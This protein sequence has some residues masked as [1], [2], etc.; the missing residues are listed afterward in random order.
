VQDAVTAGN[1]KRLKWLE[2]N[3]E[4]SVEELNRQWKRAHVGR[5]GWGAEGIIL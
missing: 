4:A 1:T 2:Q 3:P 5:M